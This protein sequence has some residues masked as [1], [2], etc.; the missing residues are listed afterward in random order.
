M[1]W[2]NIVVLRVSGHASIWVLIRPTQVMSVEHADNGRDELRC[3]LGVATV[4]ADRRCGSV[5]PAGLRRMK[6][7]G[8]KSSCTDPQLSSM[9]A[10]HSEDVPVRYAVWFAWVSPKRDRK[11]EKSEV[12]LSVIET[13]YSNNITAYAECIKIIILCHFAETAKTNCVI[14]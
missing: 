5:S 9:H 1:C 10:D 12:V 11:D 7:E 6:Q 14:M 8:I 4:S 2:L 3:P 13:D